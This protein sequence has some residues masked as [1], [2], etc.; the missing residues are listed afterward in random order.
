MRQCAEC[1]KELERRSGESPK[2]FAARRFCSRKCTAAA[3]SRRAS[4]LAAERD[5]STYKVIERNGYLMEYVGGG[6]YQYQHRLVM[7]KHLGRKRLSNEV[8]DH[9]PGG[10]HDNR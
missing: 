4:V 5:P 7:E 3:G 10:K 8:V 9:G 2:R 1:G 6:R